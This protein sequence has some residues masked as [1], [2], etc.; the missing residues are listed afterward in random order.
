MAS[1]GACNSGSTALPKRHVQRRIENSHTKALRLPIITA[2]GEKVAGLAARDNVDHFTYLW[3][4]CEIELLECECR[5]AV[6]SEEGG[7]VPD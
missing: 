4:L 6:R 1:A 7:Q 2:E 5:A 3:Q